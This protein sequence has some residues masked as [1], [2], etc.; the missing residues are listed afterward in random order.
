[1][2]KKYQ[3]ANII[4]LFCFFI[5][6]P[7]HS[8]QKS[9][10]NNI[11]VEKILGADISFLPE[12]EARGKIF[13]NNGIAQDAI[14]L[15]KEKGFNYIRLRIFVDPAADSG[16][17][18]KKGFCDLA[19]TLVMAKRIKAAGMKLLLDFHYSDTWADP[20]KQF[21]PAAW[22]NLSNKGIANAVKKHTV[23]VLTALK[24][25]Q[26]LPDMVQVGN[27]INHG[28]LW[29]EGNAKNFNTLAKFIQAGI[30]GVKKVNKKIPIMLHIALGGQS[31][32]S[33][34]FLNQLAARHVQFDIIGQSYYPQWHGTLDDLKN[35]LNDLAIK[36]PQPIIVVEYSEKK[37]AVNEIAF[38]I[39]NK[40]IKGSFIWEPLNTWEALFDKQGKATA[41]LA[42]YPEFAKNYL[43]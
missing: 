37:S 14:L 38:G 15:L 36:Y 32:E 7:T 17:S 29:P 28:I 22:K 26:T 5:I 30:V 21:K 24:N 20:G 42:L 2:I 16:Y 23:E 11:D 25:Q 3:I 27:E 1:M 6:P 33:I 43:Q 12:L 18:P 35:N 13:Y 8:Q 34:Y 19:H 39:P 4:F 31:E 41:F 10:A 9:S 40:P